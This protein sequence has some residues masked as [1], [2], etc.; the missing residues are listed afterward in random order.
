M[1]RLLDFIQE[2]EVLI[3]RFALASLE[4]KLG[5][6]FLF[7]GPN[8][9]GK[10]MAA[11]ALSQAMLCEKSQNNKM[12]LACGE[13]GSCLRIEN[14]QH[15]GLLIIEPENKQIKI[16]QARR[17]L[18]FL[19]LQSV[20]KV[21]TIIIDGIELMNVQSSNSLLKILE[22]PPQNTFFFLITPSSEHVL[23]TVRSRTQ[24]V[25]FPAGKKSF[26]FDQDELQMKESAAN[27][28]ELWMKN[29]KAY[30]LPEFRE[31]VRGKEN[32]LL[33]ARQL[34]CLFRDV[35]MWKAGERS[36]FLNPDKKTLFQLISQ[37]SSEKMNRVSRSLL[38]L[39]GSIMANRDTQLVF[40]EFWIETQAL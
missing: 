36:A 13:C 40:E 32:A 33:F 1:A 23:S 39:E 8:E 34:I 7:V 10:K 37:I 3:S 25:R 29:P 27:F 28:L 6:A 38:G 19:S 26:A 24:I 11:L 14:K 17:L 2:Y 31:M 21:R 16:E 22:E 18:D 15:E 9:S 35:M 4:N 20:S 12:L 5:H 30:L